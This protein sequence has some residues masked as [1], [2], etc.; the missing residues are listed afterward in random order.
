[1][2]KCRFNPVFQEVICLQKELVG[3]SGEAGDYVNAEED[4]GFFASVGVQFSRFRIHLFADICYFVG[5][6]F[7]CILTADVL[8][9]RVAAALKRNMEMWQELGAGSYPVHDVVGQQ[10]R[11]D[12]RNP[13]S[14]NALHIVERF[15]QIQETLPGLAAEVASVDAGE[16]D[17]LH[18]RCCYFLSFAYGFVNADA[19]APST[20][21]WHSAVGAEVVASVLHFQERP[22]AL[23]AAGVCRERFLLRGCGGFGLSP[24]GDVVEGGGDK[25]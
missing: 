3:F 2:D 5:E 20:C 15:Q 10:V 8:Q 22:R 17:F 18:A 13:V 7:R 4:V 12:G 11:L 24:L 23:L 16:H 1:M 21:V 14:L 25:G 19:T 9:N 6:K